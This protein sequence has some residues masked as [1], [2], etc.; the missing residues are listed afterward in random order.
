MVDFYGSLEF[1]PENLC[2]RWGQSDKYS[3]YKK[4][5]SIFVGRKV[6]PL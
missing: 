5:N 4:K 6:S 2:K 1:L 3:T